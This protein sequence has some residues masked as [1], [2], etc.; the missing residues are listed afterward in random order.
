MTDAKIV[1][2]YAITNRLVSAEQKA[3]V[4]VIGAGPSGVAAAIAAAQGGASVLLVDENPVSA[5]LMGLD[6]PLYFGG[7]M[8]RAV[9]N[10]ARMIE[11]IF[12]ADPQL[13]QAFEAGV[14]VALG[15]YAWGAFQNGPGIAAMPEAAVGLADEDRSWMVA[16]KQ[17]ILA[18]GARDLSLSFQG[19]DQPG[20]MGANGLHALIKRYDAFAGTQVLILGSGDLALNTALMVVEAGLKVVALIE[21][22]DQVQGE[23]AL[24]DAVRAKGIEILTGHVI[25]SASG[26]ADGVERAIVAPVGGGESRIFACD[27][28]CQALGLV[29][30]I[31]LFNVLGGKLAVRSDL[32]GHVPV[33][34][35]AVS[36]GL[37]N[38]LVAGDCAGLS[39]L[40][41]AD[42]GR[43]AAALALAALAGQPVADEAAA[44]AT[45]GFDAH[46]YHTDWITALMAVGDDSIVVCQC[47]EVTRGD[48]TA[49]RQPRY[50]GPPSEV[51]AKRDITT[52]AADG[53]LNQDQFKRL[54]RACMGQC[55]ARRCREQVALILAQSSGVPVAKV[56]LAGYRTP[57]RPLPMSVLSDMQEPYDMTANWDVWFGIASQWVPYNDIGTEREAMHIAMLTDSQHI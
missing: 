14:E 48:L 57:V 35:G 5:S 12:A 50:L 56:P 43:A 25:L 11:Q 29:P 39:D 53:P 51:A 24:A 18:T 46:A 42:H 23:A 16:Y 34:T 19:W 44:A 32:G 33:R 13:E 41:A 30:A 49:V 45:A 28:V 40:D 20:V 21:V 22:R 3:D 4:V 17:L 2:R 38:V 36:T 8:T 54:T 52:L 37:A 7:R 10:K 26:G 1:D 6:T 31:E 55:Q 9:D 27:T 15:V 47:E